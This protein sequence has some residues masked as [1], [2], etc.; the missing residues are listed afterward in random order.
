MK[1]ASSPIEGG[2]IKMAGFWLNQ[3]SIIN[4]RHAGNPLERM[5]DRPL[6]SYQQTKH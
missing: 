6:L 5:E 1:A 4:Q 3:Q 2:F